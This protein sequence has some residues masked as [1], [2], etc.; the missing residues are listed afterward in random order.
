M[1]GLASLRIAVRR[2]G[3]RNV[4]VLR[5]DPDFINRRS[6]PFAVE[7]RLGKTL[8][9]R[10]FARAEGRPVCLSRRVRPITR[11]CST[12][13]SLTACSSFVENVVN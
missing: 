11:V 3:S 5:V 7:M 8:G 6:A 10:V 12:D 4:D 1:T 9:M 2:L 13:R